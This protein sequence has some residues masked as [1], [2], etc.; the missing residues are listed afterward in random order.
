M[1]PAENRQV[2]LWPPTRTDNPTGE[3]DRTCS[4]DSRGKLH[5]EMLPETF[6]GEDPKGAAILVESARSAINLRFQGNSK[7]SVLITDKG[8]GFWNPGTGHITQEYKD[9][10]CKFKFTTFMGDDATLQPANAADLMLHETA[11]AWVRKR[12]SNTLPKNEWLET[13]E[14]Y[15]HRLKEV[16]TFINREHDVKGLCHGFSKRVDDLIDRGGDRLAK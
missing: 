11:V 5:L 12:L 16:A 6:P 14:E 15:G 2:Q 9:A 1:V 4:H 7:P 13:R 10:V 8:R 3:R